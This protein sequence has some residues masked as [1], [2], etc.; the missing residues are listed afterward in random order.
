MYFILYVHNDAE[1]SDESLN[2]DLENEVCNLYTRN[3]QQHFFFYLFIYLTFLFF[4]FNIVNI[5]F[6]LFKIIYFFMQ[7]QI[8]QSTHE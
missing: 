6:I 4:K 2:G 8:L 5:T 1:K 7:I 3:Q